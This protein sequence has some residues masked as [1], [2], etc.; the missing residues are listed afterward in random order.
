MDAP[1]GGETMDDVKLLKL[2]R[3]DP[4]RGIEFI[5]DEYAGLVYAVVRGRLV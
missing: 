3:K 5:M 2:L 1:E 4:N